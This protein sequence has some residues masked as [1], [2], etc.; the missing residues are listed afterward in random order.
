MRLYAYTWAI[1]DKTTTPSKE[2]RIPRDARPSYMHARASRSYHFI[3]HVIN[4]A[5]AYVDEHRMPAY[6]INA[7]PLSIL[8]MSPRLLWRV[9]SY[10]AHESRS[11]F[12]ITYVFGK[13]I[14]NFYHYTV[15]SQISSSKNISV[16]SHTIQNRSLSYA[17]STRT[18]N[19]RKIQHPTSKK[20]A[21]NLN[22]F[23]HIC[24]KTFFSS[25]KVV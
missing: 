16:K 4:R 8:E 2:P 21:K 15:F 3:S 9:V 22:C 20:C 23:S 5:S 24:Q 18:S 7:A 25:Y 19:E 13:I 11:N 14:C 1:S 12:K 17:Q 6:N 10:D